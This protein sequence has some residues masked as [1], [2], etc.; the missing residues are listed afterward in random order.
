MKKK[1]AASKSVKDKN[2]RAIARKNLQSNKGYEELPIQ[3]VPDILYEIDTKGKFTFISNAIKDAGYEPVDLIGKHFKTILHPDD[4]KKA[5]HAHV[6]TKY[7]GRVTGD[8]GAPKLFDE[9]R[10]GSRGTKNLELRMAIKKKN[11]DEK[12][13]YCYVEISSAGKWYKSIRD[14]RK[15][16]KGTIGIIRDITERKKAE[17]I[18]KTTQKKLRENALRLQK[19]NRVIHKLNKELEKKN[20]RLQELDKLKTEFISTVSHELRT[21]LTSIREGVSQVLEGIL[22]GIS[23]KQREFLSMSLE[24][25][26]RLGRIIND[27][28]DISKIEEN[29]I[30][31]KREMVDISEL[32]RYARSTLLKQAEDKGL[33]I[34]EKY[35]R[36]KTKLYVNKDKIIQVFINLIGNAIKFTKEGH[37]TISVKEKKDEVECVVADTGIGISAKNKA[38]IFERFHQINRASGPGAKGTGLGLAIAKGIIE[39]HKGSIRVESRTKKGSRFIFTIPRDT[40][41]SVSR[42]FV[43]SSVREAIKKETTLSVLVFDFENLDVLKQ[44]IGSKKI[45]T[46]VKNLDSLVG[47]NLR[48][49]DDISVKGA[50][51][52]LVM[53]PAT[54]KEGA[55]MVARRLQQVL[56]DYLAQERMDDQEIMCDVVGLPEDRQNAEKMLN[57]IDKKKK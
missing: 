25:I 41:E 16:F 15:K 9:R 4:Y 19:N 46:L 56:S 5:S 35:P 44:K 42:K 7:K 53:L 6:I 13:D 49:G 2:S 33:K 18:L 47:E 27:L 20:I 21:P 50:R 55:V 45:T 38:R 36:H 51:A 39:A 10:T 52:I 17:K 48:R 26:D 23:D 11:K 37:I 8:A 34:K 32:A 14:H 22:G 31:I 12:K 28:L 54:G 40:K 24:D 29:K 1:R 30:E 3:I 43:A 57:R